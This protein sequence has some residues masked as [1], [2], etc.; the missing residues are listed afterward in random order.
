MWHVTVTVT[1]TVTVMCAQWH[2]G[3]ALLARRSGVLTPA[4]CRNE[5]LDLLHH[6]SSDGFSRPWLPNYANLPQRAAAALQQQQQQS[7]PCRV[8]VLRLDV[9][10]W[11]VLIVRPR[12][13]FI[14][15]N[16]PWV[17]NVGE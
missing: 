3:R 17:L 15:Q 10:Q 13:L 14:C 6:L 7:A 16:A 1:V 2:R 9:P 11:Q 4:L 8:Q 12:T 5:S